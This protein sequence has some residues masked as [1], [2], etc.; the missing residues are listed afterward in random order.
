[1]KSL[2][3]YLLLFL[4]ACM[5][6]ATCSA[7]A[8]PEPITVPQNEPLKSCGLSLRHRNG[9]FL[10]GSPLSNDFLSKGVM[11]SLSNTEPFGAKMSFIIL[12]KDQLL[13]FYV[14][15][16]TSQQYQHFFNVSEEGTADFIV[17]LPLDLLNERVEPGTCVY[18]IALGAI[19]YTLK[20]KY[21]VG[22]LD[23]PVVPVMLCGNE[24][25]NAPLEFYRD[26][27]PFCLIRFEHI[28]DEETS[29]WRYQVTKNEKPLLAF[30]NAEPF[31]SPYEKGV[32]IP[33]VN[34]SLLMEGD[35]PMIIHPK[36]IDGVEKFTI[37]PQLHKGANSIIFIY[38]PT[39]KHAVYDQATSDLFTV[40]VE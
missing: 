39:G 27:G 8:E 16:Q 12:Y 30:E 35:T 10:D 9:D 4:A 33:I 7:Q 38:L 15:D 5:L 1:M 18:F 21:D 23:Y 13:P 29:G 11:V 24:P 19:D 37:Q 31:S 6:L 28:D 2:H 26:F 3:H 34:G 25:A 17:R 22:G 20:D 32:V 40:V 36:N 14:G